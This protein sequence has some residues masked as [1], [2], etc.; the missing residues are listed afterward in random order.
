MNRNNKHKTGPEVCTSEPVKLFKYLY[1]F[2]THTFASE[3]A[4]VSTTL[5]SSL[6]QDTTERVARTANRNE[7]SFFIFFNSLK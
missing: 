3:A 5:A 1:F 6:L 2:S 7:L 4:G